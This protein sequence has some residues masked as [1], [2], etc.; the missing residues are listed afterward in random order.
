MQLFCDEFYPRARLSHKRNV[1][2]LSLLHSYVHVKCLDKLRYLIPP[3]ITFTPRTQYTRNT[4]ANYLHSL[5]IPHVRSNFLMNIFFLRIATFWNRLERECFSDHN[6]TC[7]ELWLNVNFPTYAEPRTTY[8][9]SHTTYS[10]SNP[11]PRRALGLCAERI[12]FK[13]L[14]KQYFYS[15]VWLV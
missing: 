9:A 7:P 1:G 10:F 6:L 14:A 13:K 3:V 2:N 12:L 5:R 15:G 4:V 11:L 8:F